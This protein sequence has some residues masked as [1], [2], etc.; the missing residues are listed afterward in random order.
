MSNTVANTNTDAARFIDPRTVMRIK[1]LQLRARVV[2]EG[3]YAGIHRS[4]YHGFSVEFSE[5]RAYS[6]GDDPRYLDWRLFARSD[7][8]CIKRF[9]DETSL[10]CYLV[11]DMS[12]SMGFGSGSYTKGDYARILAASLAYFMFTQR[13]AVGLVTFADAVADYLPPRH[14][15]GH[16]R[17]LFG[18]LDR[19]LVGRS[20]DLTRPLERI[21]ESVRKRGLVVLISDLLAPVAAFRTR[22]GY[23][24]SR[25][26][27]VLVLQV[28]DPAE[29][30]FTFTAPQMFHDLESGRRLYIDPPAARTEYQ[31]RF[32]EH[33]HQLKQA[34]LD[35][36]VDFTRLTTDQPLELALFDLLHLRERRGRRIARRAGRQRQ[37]ARAAT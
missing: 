4:P 14:R 10:L 33:A 21:A 5:Y 11:V 8:Y 2:V 25:G 3:F 28:L 26:H 20:T 1:N 6:P 29:V 13:D 15:A 24:R 12:R 31:R 27:D 22:L 18:M 19:E 35:L 17:R 34:C 9:E 7:R 37:T 36:G 30:E 16:L 23:L 32:N